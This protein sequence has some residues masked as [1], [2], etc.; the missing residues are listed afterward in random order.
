M[1]WLKDGG[2]IRRC[3]RWCQRRCLQRLVTFVHNESDDDN[4]CGNDDRGGEGD[5]VGGAG[6]AA[7]RGGGAVTN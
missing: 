2:D 4:E 5:V 3:S 6:D 1:G 7:S